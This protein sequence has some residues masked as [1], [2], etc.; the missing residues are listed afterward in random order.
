MLMPV[1]LG[2]ISLVI[3]VLLANVFWE[4][5]RAWKLY[6]KKHPPLTLVET[7]FAFFFVML[8]F[9]LAYV[10]I[11]TFNRIKRMIQDRDEMG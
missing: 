1:F 11:P 9:A 6:A 4:I 7:I 2:L 5:Y 3:L 10:I 8:L